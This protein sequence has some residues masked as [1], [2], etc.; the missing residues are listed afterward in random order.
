MSYSQVF[1]WWLFKGKEKEELGL[2]FKN[3]TFILQLG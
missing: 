3:L 1:N 2:V